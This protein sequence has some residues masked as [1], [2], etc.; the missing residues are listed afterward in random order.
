[1]S[2]F[3]L[4]VRLPSL[5]AGKQTTELTV[6][7]K[8]TTLGELIDLLER[9][10]SGFQQAHDA[11]MIFAVNGELVIQGERGRRIESGDEIEMMLALAGG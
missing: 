11:H 2:A 9:E 8:L 4:R 1:M 5:T 6:T 3:S 7:K 10:H